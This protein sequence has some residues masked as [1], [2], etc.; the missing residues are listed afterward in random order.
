ML[1]F[2]Y[3]IFVGSSLAFRRLCCPASVVTMIDKIGM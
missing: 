2:S 3:N 1:V